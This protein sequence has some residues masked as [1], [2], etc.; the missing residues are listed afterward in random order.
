MSTCDG[1]YVQKDGLAMGSPAAPPLANIWMSKFDKVFIQK[2][3]KIYRRY[4]DDILTA[5]KRL[6]L[7][8]TMVEINMMHESL[9][10]T[11]ESEDKDA[12]LSFLDMELKHE[13][14][15]ITSTW[16]TKP[17]S[18]GLTLNFNAMA[19]RR[20]KRSIVKSF[21]HRVYNACSNWANFHLS[22]EKAKTILENNQYPKSFYE[23]IIH[24]TLEKIVLKKI[25]KDKM[26]WEET[27]ADKKLFL[28]NTEVL[29][30]ANIFPS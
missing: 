17:T 19:P 11:Y 13:N 29:K 1:Y 18:T 12:K 9:K 8:S 20:Y 24:D 22:L 26:S 16:Y 5:V 3:S 21:I 15:K 2:K 14:C 25:G 30:P 6:E 28:Y 4:V 7:E 10:F 23:P 27:I